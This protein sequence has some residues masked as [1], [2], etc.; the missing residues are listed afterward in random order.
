MLQSM[1]SSDVRIIESCN[2]SWHSA[3]C[4]TCKH[5]RMC[6]PGHLPWDTMLAAFMASRSNV[7]AWYAL[8]IH[9]IPSIIAI[10]YLLHIHHNVGMLPANQLQR[11]MLR[12][13]IFFLA[14]DHRVVLLL[15]AVCWTSDW[16]CRGAGR[17]QHTHMCQC[18]LPC[19]VDAQCKLQWS[20]FIGAWHSE[21][22]C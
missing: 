3:G 1:I 6:Q 16:Q 4:S 22:G 19:A 10:C 21:W 2:A 8:F 17:C 13:M 14:L 12:I 20:K 11:Y 9:E 18:R 5:D 15:C 7:I